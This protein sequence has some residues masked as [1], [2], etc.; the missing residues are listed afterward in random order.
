METDRVGWLYQRI[1]QRASSVDERR[2]GT[3]Y[4]AALRGNNVPEEE[5]WREYIHVLLA[6]NEFLFID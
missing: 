1:Y 2:T 4:V 6:S 3:E 5:A